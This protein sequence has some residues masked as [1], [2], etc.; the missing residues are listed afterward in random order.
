[1]EETADPVTDL[2]VAGSPAL[3]GSGRPFGSQY[4]RRSD[5][6]ATKRAAFR[7]HRGL[8][9][10]NL[11]GRVDQPIDLP[12]VVAESGAVGHR[13]NLTDAICRENDLPLGRKM[14]SFPA[15]F[16]RPIVAGV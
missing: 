7:H 4:K 5:H 6:S 15:R 14:K 12:Q 2:A 13:Q 16:R 8:D 3:R 11:V 1:M 9:E 10:R